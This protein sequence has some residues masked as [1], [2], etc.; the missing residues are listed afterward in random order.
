MTQLA[1]VAD[2]L[3]GATDTSACFAVPNRARRSACSAFRRRT[4]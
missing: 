3:T 4:K 1:I 2:D